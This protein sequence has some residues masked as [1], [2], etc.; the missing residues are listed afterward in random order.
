[1]ADQPLGGGPGL[2][3]GFAHDHVQ[4]DAELHRAA[5]LG[6][7]RAHVG[8]LLRHRLRRLAPGQVQLDLLGGQLV[9]RL[10]RTT[11]VQRWARLLNRRV[12]QLGALDLDVLAVE[13]DGFAFQHLA[14]DMGELHGGLVALG[15]AE[16][17][18]V[19]R[20]FVRI[21]TGD[22]VEQRAAVGQAVE[23]RRLTGGHGRRDDAGTQGDEELE[24]LGGRDQRGGDQPGVLAGTPGGNQHAAVAEAVGGLGHLGQVAVVDGAG[25]FGG[26]Q[27]VAVAVGGE[28]PEDVQTHRSIPGSGRAGGGA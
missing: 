15:V 13:V 11:E 3:V 7:A 22:Q 14:P 24:A 20:Q 28:K 19:G 1:M 23:G 17:E 2:I 26:A 9:G 12:E 6:G 4:A 16:V 25:A 5:M 18:A 10:G 27:V 8:D 21:A